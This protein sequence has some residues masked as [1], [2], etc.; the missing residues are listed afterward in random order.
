MKEIARV[1]KYKGK[2]YLVVQ[3]SYYKDIHCDLAKIIVDMCT[4][5]GL[6]HISTNTFYSK[7]NMANINPKGKKNTE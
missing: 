1:L 2:C 4:S 3:D 7:N 5:L 6:K